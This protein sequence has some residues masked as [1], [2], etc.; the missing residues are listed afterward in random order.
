MVK[1][2]YIMS[3][4]QNLVHLE[5]KYL[6][7][8]WIYYVQICMTDVQGSDTSDRKIFSRLSILAELLYAKIF[9]I[10]YPDSYR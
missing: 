1:M 4:D 10:Q 7:Y 8:Y 9:H 6:P 3:Q 5:K 2:V